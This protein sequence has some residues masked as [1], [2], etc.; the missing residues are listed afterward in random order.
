MQKKA[1][2]GRSKYS[3]GQLKK[4]KQ[5]IVLTVNGRA[6]LVVQDAHGYQELLDRLD[7]IETAHPAETI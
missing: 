5:P 6:A 3:I 4:S 1:I 2:V 7:R